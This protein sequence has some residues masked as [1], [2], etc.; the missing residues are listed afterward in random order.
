MYIVL[1]H[2]LHRTLSGPDL[3][4]IS[5]LIISCI[6][7]YVTNKKTLNLAKSIGSPLSNERFNH[8]TP[9]TCTYGYRNF[10]HFTTVATEVEIQFLSIL[11]MFPSLLPRFGSAFFS[12]KEGVVPVLLSI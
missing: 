2:I 8:Q 7:E 12:S 4:Y 9:M 6:I 10:I 1:L 5:L 3:T 11:I